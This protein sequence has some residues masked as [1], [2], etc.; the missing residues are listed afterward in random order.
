VAKVNSTDE[1]GL[2]SSTFNNMTRRLRDQVTDLEKRVAERTQALEQRAQQIQAA[3]DIGN[4]AARIR[5]VKYLL[6]QAVQMI[7]LR[8][9]YY[10]V[11]I[12]LLDEKGE[13]ALLTA[14]NSEGGQRMLARKHKLPVGKVGIVGYVT[15]TGQPRIALDVGQDAIFFDNPDLP[16]TRSEMALPLLAGEK[17]LGALDVQ[18]TQEAA[19]SEDD[20]VTLKVLADQL[21]IA[22]ENANLFAETQLAAEAAR[23]AYGEVS[24]HD[25]QK[26]L[27]EKQETLGYVS[28]Q[29]DQAVPVSGESQPGFQEAAATGKPAISNDGTTLHVPIAVR[30]RSIGAIQIDKAQGSGRWSQDDIEVA[31]SLA[32]QLSTALE[33]ARL[34]GDASRRANRERLLSEISAKVGATIRMDSILATAVEAVGRAFSDSDVILQINEFEEEKLHE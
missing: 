30:G 27:Q 11:G 18:S 12:F 14:A 32:E 20:I 21:S 1:V 15:A 5:D 28:F 2:L 3:A 13:Y 10:H 17:V 6:P 26:L 22:I 23:R 8:F 19:F 29:E 7:A 34:Y 16:E 25:W 24:I 4:A 31:H 33:S 9:N